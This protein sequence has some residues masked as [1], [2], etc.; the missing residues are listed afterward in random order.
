MWIKIKGD[1]INLNN[2][3][4]INAIKGTD[5]YSRNEYKIEFETIRDRYE[6][7]SIDHIEVYYSCESDM[8]KDYE[9]IQTISGCK[10]I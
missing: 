3:I 4:R 7:Y 1:L 5:G 10:E 9:K 2:V 6:R 8:L